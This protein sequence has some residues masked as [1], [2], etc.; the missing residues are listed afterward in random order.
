[1]LISVV[2]V[3]ACGA[4]GIPGLSS[5][6]EGSGSVLPQLKAL[7]SKSRVSCLPHGRLAAGLGSQPSSPGPQA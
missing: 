5:E 1:M 3:T 4:H 7:I 6:G 2:I